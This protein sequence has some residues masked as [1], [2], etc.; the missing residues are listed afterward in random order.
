M[1]TIKTTRRETIIVCVHLK[2]HLRGDGSLSYYS[3]K[4]TYAWFL[5]DYERNYDVKI[6]RTTTTTRPRSA[7]RTKSQEIIVGFYDTR[8][9]VFYTNPHTYRYF[10]IPSAKTQTVAVADNICFNYAELNYKI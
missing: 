1:T 6:R 3:P 7:A 2:H 10:L 4:Y 9:L 8:I 5:T